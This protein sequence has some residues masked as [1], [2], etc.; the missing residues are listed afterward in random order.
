VI[1][2]IDYGTY[3]DDEQWEPT[4]YFCPHCGEQ[5]VYQEIED[6]FLHLCLECHSQSDIIFCEPPDKYTKQRVEQIRGS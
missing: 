1:V 6:G 2:T 5:S 3:E 4:N